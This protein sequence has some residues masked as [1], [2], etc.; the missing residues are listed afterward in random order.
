MKVWVIIDGDGDIVGVYASEIDADRKLEEPSS[1]RKVA[2]FLH[3]SE[4]ISI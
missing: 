4:R 2:S 1:Y 3:Y